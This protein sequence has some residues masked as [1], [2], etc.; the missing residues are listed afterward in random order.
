MW[1]SI[2]FKS[3]ERKKTWKDAIDRLKQV[4]AKEQTQ[5]FK[6]RE[7]DLLRSMYGTTQVSKSK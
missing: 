2:S 6:D 7:A 4:F 5:A 1:K 3:T